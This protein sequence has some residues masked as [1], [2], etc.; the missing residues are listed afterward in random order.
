MEIWRRGVEASEAH[1]G[2]VLRLKQQMAGL[3]AGLAGWVKGHRYLVPTAVES[4]ESGM[5]LLM[6]WEVDHQQAYP[7]G[8]GEGLSGALVGFS[9]RLQERVC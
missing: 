6:L 1:S 7:S 2:P 8:G 4:G 9:R 3:D 5:A